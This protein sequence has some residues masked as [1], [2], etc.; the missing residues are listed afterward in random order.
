[1]SAAKHTPAPLTR[2]DIARCWREAY[3]GQRMDATD[4]DF[5]RRVEMAAMEA[6]G[7]ADLLEALQGMLEVYGVTAA[8]YERH[9]VGSRTE[10]ALCD[11]ARA[12]ICKAMGEDA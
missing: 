3:G 10:V 5:A 7:A 1:M 4:E 9:G 2:T 8:D 12:A 11:Q 6:V